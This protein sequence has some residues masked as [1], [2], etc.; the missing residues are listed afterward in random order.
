[1]TAKLK[2][3]TV[4]KESKVNRE[5][6]KAGFGVNRGDGWGNRSIKMEGIFVLIGAFK[7]DEV[8]HG[9]DGLFAG[10]SRAEAFP[11][12]GVRVVIVVS[13]VLHRRPALGKGRRDAQHVFISSVTGLATLS[14]SLFQL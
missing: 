3:N 13:G 9:D 7:V 12:D 10:Q 14:G 2:K 6:T 8:D 1:M 11:H 4:L 5:V